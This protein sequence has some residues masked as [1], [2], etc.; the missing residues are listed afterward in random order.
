MGVKKKD[1]AKRKV[2]GRREEGND[3]G[4]WKITMRAGDG[5]MEFRDRSR[6]T[7]T[8]E[9]KAISLQRSQRE[10]WHSS[11]TKGDSAINS[12]NPI[13]IPSS[14]PRRVNTHLHHAAKP[15][16]PSSICKGERGAVEGFRDGWMDG[17]INR[18]PDSGTFPLL[19]V[20]TVMTGQ[21]LSD[22]LD[23]NTDRRAGPCGLQ[24]QG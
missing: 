16:L 1:A 4:R 15:L 23:T 22:H 17:W 6:S 7:A 2:R 14:S 12:I 3:G 10:A 9:Q 5:E 21:L 19:R 8:A 11:P 24:V 13:S 18:S 20:W